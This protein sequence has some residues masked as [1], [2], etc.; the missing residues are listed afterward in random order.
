[1][2]NPLHLR[3]LVAVVQTGSFAAAARRLGYTGSAVSQQIAALERT[4][5]LPLFDRNAQSIQPTPVAAL[6]VVRAHE[7][8]SALGALDQEIRGM[9]EGSIGQLRLGSFPTASERLIPAV[10]VRCAEAHP[11]VQIQLNEGEPEELIALLSL[12]E[13]DI[14]LVYKYDF[15]PLTWPQ[16]VRST[17]LMDE[18]LI[19]LLPDKHPF[20]YANN[21][22]LEDLTNETWI[23]SREG[24]AGSAC[25]KRICTG[26]GFDPAIGY[27]SNDYDVVR[28]FVRL[29]LGIALVPALAHV[30]NDGIAA[31]TI[32]NVTASRHVIALN[33]STKRNPAIVLTA[34]ILKDCAHQLRS[35]MAAETRS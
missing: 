18:D 25:L 4:V 23:T 32:T 31:K 1:M 14:A 24:S 10:L 5:K 33:R 20:A 7:V 22:M 16:D 2:L 19:L 15:V 3:T 26:A 6:L 27:R 28:E 17:R 11:A 29:G 8:L 34:S 35:K 21:I 30:A 12:G 13:L 9:V